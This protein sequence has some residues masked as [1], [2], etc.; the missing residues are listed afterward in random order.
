MWI[1]ESSKLFGGMDILALD[2]V[3]EANSEKEYILE[4]NDCSIGLGRQHEDEDLVL[5]R[6]LILQKMIIHFSS[7]KNEGSEANRKVDESYKRLEVELINSE[8]TKMEMQKEVKNLKY[9]MQILIE[10]NKKLK[11]YTMKY[12][13]KMVG[14]SLTFG[15]AVGSIFGF[16]IFKYWKRN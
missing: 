8:N 2:V 15:I 5:I 14:A 6:D 1:D 3:H 10:S 12:L 7:G 11:D 13:S 4:M 9:Q 16:L